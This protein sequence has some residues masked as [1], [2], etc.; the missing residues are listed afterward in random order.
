MPL[1]PLRPRAVILLFLIGSVVAAPV[2]ETPEPDSAATAIFAGG[3]FWC[4]EPAFETLPGVDSV[5][6]GYTGGQGPNPNF[7]S[8]SSGNSAYVEA[9]QVYYHPRRIGY[10]KLLDAYW[11]NIDPTRADGQFSDEGA[12]FRTL[13]FYREEA[14]R[15]AAEASMKRLQKS[16]RF[17]KP[18]VT[19]IAEATVFYP[20]ESE[21]QD[22]YVK[23]K[24]RYKAYV[25][26]SGREAFFKKVWG[27]KPAK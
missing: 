23:S 25:R 7:E 10:S 3:S 16:K 20:A 26:F 17:S 9:V 24:A 2:P 14:E 5:I 27:A 21:H 12:Q 8:V 18:L 4:M 11:K 6:S 19:E 22:Y 15:I 13:I 1:N